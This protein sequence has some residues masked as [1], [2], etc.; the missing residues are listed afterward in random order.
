MST[1][2]G[3]GMTFETGA[4]RNGY[5]DGEGVKRWADHDEIVRGYNGLHDE[6]TPNRR[7]GEDGCG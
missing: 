6:T 3:F 2:R 4:F 1:L 5:I 7:G